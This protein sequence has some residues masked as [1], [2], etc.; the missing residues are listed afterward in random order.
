MNT[1]P[2][3]RRRAQDRRVALI[4]WRG[5]PLAGRFTHRVYR[6]NYANELAPATRHLTRRGADRAARAWAER[7]AI[8]GIP[9]DRT[10][11]AAALKRAEAIA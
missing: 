8:R 11:I 9:A 2:P 10:R 1:R 7:A 5:C 4:R 6:S 3:S